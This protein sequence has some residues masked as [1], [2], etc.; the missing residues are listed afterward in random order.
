MIPHT[1]LRYIYKRSIYT[2]QLITRG[3]IQ[4]SEKSCTVW[5][6]I[7]TIAITL[8]CQKHHNIKP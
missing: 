8:V 2:A 6:L 3:F 7:K 5:N 4:R 1:E